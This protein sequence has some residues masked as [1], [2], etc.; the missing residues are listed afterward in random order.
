V[1]SD[2][3]GK[4]VVR[5]AGVSVDVGSDGVGKVVVGTKNWF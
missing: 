1:G 4:V 2:G 5:S 3:V